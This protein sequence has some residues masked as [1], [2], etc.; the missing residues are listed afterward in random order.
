[1]TNSEFEQ[2]EGTGD[3]RALDAGASAWFDAPSLTAGAALVRRIAELAE[4]T[5]LPDVDLRPGGVRVRVGARDVARARAISAAAQEL[6]LAADPAALQAVHLAIDVTDRPAVLS[7]WRT[8]LAYEPVGDH[9]LRDP[10]RRDPAISFHRQDQPRPLRNRIHVDVG[11]TP[12]AV[13][14]AR[15]AVGREA[16]GPYQLTLADPDGNEIDLVPGDDLPGGPQTADWRTLF[17]AMA[18]YPVASPVR[19]SELACAVAGLADEAG[20]PLL[21]DLRSAGVTID[22]GKDQWE[23]SGHPAG[24]QFADLAGRIQTAARDLGLAAD[25]SRL[26]FVQL[27]IDAVD[28]PAVRAF[29]T[30]VLGYRHDPRTFLTDIYDPRRLN[31]VLFV[32]DMDASEEDRRRQR[33]RIHLDLFVPSDQ[34]QVRIDAAA[35]AGGRVLRTTPGR[36]TIADPEGNELTICSVTDSRAR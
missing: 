3:W 9:G 12:D 7:F 33:N 26:R 35:A 1:M 28:V 23:D 25:T 15:A 36:H 5:G 4:G 14:A 17:G 34:V 11:R 31:P 6:G 19:A 16:Y 24:N 8:T 20:L 18:F 30:A 13:R 27:G 2:A 32:Q 21:V 22:S 29:W 10:L